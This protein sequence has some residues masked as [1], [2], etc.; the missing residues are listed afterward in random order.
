MPY[1]EGVA[2][3]AHAVSLHPLENR[4]YDVVELIELGWL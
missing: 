2:A 4:H 3:I 1:V